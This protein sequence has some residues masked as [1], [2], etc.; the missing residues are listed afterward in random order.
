MT[1]VVTVRSQLPE[2]LAI[3]EERVGIG[4]GKVAFDIEAQ[5]KQ[6]A[7]VRTGYL[8]S[9]IQT[10]VESEKMATVV[11][12]ASYSAYQEFGTYK[13]SAQPYMVPAIEAV[14][15]TAEKFFQNLA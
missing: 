15:P 8:R 1:I 9:A 4:V 5:A 3:V 2:V 11:A 6:R 12:G 7:P 14:A 13:M 10:T